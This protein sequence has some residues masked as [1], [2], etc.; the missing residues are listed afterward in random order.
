MAS[1][2]QIDIIHLIHDIHIASRSKTK[3]RQQLIELN[4][5][6][7]NADLGS[8][9]ELI[10]FI[11]NT[12][13]LRKKKHFWTHHKEK[14]ESMQSINWLS[15]FHNKQFTDALQRLA[16]IS[17]ICA[18]YNKDA[19]ADDFDQHFHSIRFIRECIP[20]SSPIK[21]IENNNY[22]SPNVEELFGCFEH[23]NMYHFSNDLCKQIVSYLD[24][25]AF[26]KCALINHGWF[27]LIYRNDSFNAILKQCVSDKSMQCV[28]ID[29]SSLN[30]MEILSQ[31]KFFINWQIRCNSPYLDFITLQKS[32]FTQF[33]DPHS[34]QLTLYELQKTEEDW[35]WVKVKEKQ[36]TEKKLFDTMNIFDI[37]KLT[38]TDEKTQ[39]NNTSQYRMKITVQKPFC[40][41]FYTESCTLK[42]L[43]WH[44]KYHSRDDDDLSITPHDREQRFWLEYYLDLLHSLMDCD[45]SQALVRIMEAA[46]RLGFENKIVCEILLDPVI[47]RQIV[48][49]I[50]H[51]DLRIKSYAAILLSN[52]FSTAIDEIQGEYLKL[53]TV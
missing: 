1:S 48:R 47:M 20:C 11:Q 43:E 40:W 44:R 53:C 21:G 9:V 4:A 26:F 22:S 34:I 27:N 45:I 5:E 10:H 13:N 37:S 14:R 28:L 7:K 39:E 30:R 19:S 49:L 18:L 17:P 24:I 6:I 32:W 33:V 41:T 36:K 25:C 2:E 23:L 35:Q 52:M 50:K 38:G 31:S 42:P 16:A 29:H 51:K 46:Q 15:V 12:A 8:S 3:F